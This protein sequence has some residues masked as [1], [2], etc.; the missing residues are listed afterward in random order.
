MPTEVVERVEGRSGELVLRRRSGHL[1]VILNG[2]FLISTENE[3]SSRAMVTAGLE[4]LGETPA[5]GGGATG[6]RDRKSV[7]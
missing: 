6:C 5:G 2:A 3:A 4:A 7:G 1:E